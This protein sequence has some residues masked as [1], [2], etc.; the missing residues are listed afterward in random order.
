MFHLLFSAP[1]ESPI[2]RATFLLYLVTN[3]L[4]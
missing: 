3:I 2:H 1:C 4:L